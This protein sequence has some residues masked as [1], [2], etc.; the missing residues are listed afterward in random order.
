MK[1]ICLNISLYNKYDNL[2]LTVGKVYNVIEVVRIPFSPTR[3][4]DYSGPRYK[5]VNDRG[6][7]SS[8]GEDCVR[9]LTKEEE[10]EELLKELGIT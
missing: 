9:L 3:Y 7:V 6:E 4:D 10:R 8:Y 1:V 2:P 5:L